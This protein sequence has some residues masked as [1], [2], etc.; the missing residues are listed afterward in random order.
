MSRIGPYN[1]DAMVRALADDHAR[2]TAALGEANELL[3]QR[4]EEAEH[5]RRIAED[6]CRVKSEFLAAMSHELR[7][8][9]NAIAGHAQLID[10]G[11]YGPLTEKQREAIHRIQRNQRQLLTMVDD[12]LNLRAPADL[13]AEPPDIPIPRSNKL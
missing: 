10:L 5:A 6:A 8:P 13:Q 3:A 11:V 12:V 7:T 4:A 2:L 9:L 1:D